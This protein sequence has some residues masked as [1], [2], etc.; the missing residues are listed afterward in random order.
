MNYTKNF[1][2]IYKNFL[3]SNIIKVFEIFEKIKIKIKTKNK[4]KYFIITKNHNIYNTKKK[5]SI[6]LF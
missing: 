4:I 1:I 6:L 2:C 5:K 3:K